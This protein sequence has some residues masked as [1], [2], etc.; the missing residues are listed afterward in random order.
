MSYTTFIAPH[1]T[2]KRAA[3][4]LIA[5]SVLVFTLLIFAGTRNLWL[6]LVAILALAWVLPGTLLLAYFRISRLGFVIAGLLAVGLGWC[7]MILISLFLHWLPGPIGYWEMIVTYALGAGLLL[8]GFLLRHEPLPTIT[9]PPARIALGVLVLLVF[10]SALRV[11]GLGS[12]REFYHDETFMLVRA[13]DAIRGDE[14]ALS[15]HTKGPGEIAASVAVYRALDTT[16]E[17]TARL[18]FAL[19]G[20]AAVLATAELGRRLLSPAVGFWAGI[21]VAVNGFVLALSR[22]A[23]Y[24]GAVLLL[25]ALAVLTAWEFSRNS[26]ARWGLLAVVFATFGLIMHY[27]M[28]LTGPVLLLLLWRGV[29]NASNRGRLIRVGVPATILSLSLV[30]FVYL[31]MITSSY[32]TE[33]TQN[34]YA[35]R[36]GAPGSNNIP[37]FIDIGTLYNSVYF[38]AGLLLLVVAGIV[39]GW[40]TSRD[41]TLLLLLWCLPYIVVYLLIIPIPGTHFYMFMQSWSLLAALPLAAVIHEAPRPAVRWGGAAIAAGWLVLSIGYLYLAFFQT[42]PNYL[43]NFAETQH[44]LYPVPYEAEFAHKPRVG[45]PRREGW[46]TLGVLSEWNYFVDT[47]ASN[48]EHT[49]W[50]LGD[51]NRVGFAEHPDFIFIASH[52]MEL[53]PEFDPEVLAQYQ[54][55]GEVRVHEERHIEIFAREPLAVPYAIYDAEQYDRVFDLGVPVLEETPPALQPLNVAL[56]DAIV[57]EQD[58]LR[59]TTWQRGDTLH[60]LFT[61]HPSRSLDKDYKLF[62]HVG[63]DDAGQPL[64]QW[65]GYP[66]RN[67]IRTSQLPA[68][69]TVREHV[70]VEIPDDMPTGEHE[71][72]A[73]FYDGETGQRVGGKAVPLTAIR[74]R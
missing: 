39:R 49:R 5:I 48:E 61:W 65:D 20:V 47:Y 44:P 9:L 35:A 10:T 8:A 12:E 54:R 58:G 19:M 24:Q 31:S 46:K 64:T 38:L 72:I 56:G 18:P 57:L 23:Q 29:M 30:G 59:R 68:D 60:L 53:N 69:E 28:V 27:E 62:V 40:R 45:I 63:A 15:R 66:G 7:W 41:V 4:S 74:V 42:T 33:S 11:P 34:Y 21:L 13:R 55:V 67:T 6:R 71:V 70:L 32:F 52:I 37:F 36:F 22:I 25:M 50:Y 3:F 17:A 16:N 73:G 43:I 14:D 26:D 2:T 1:S 51:L